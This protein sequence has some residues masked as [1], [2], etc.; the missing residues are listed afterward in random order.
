MTYPSASISRR[1]SSGPRCR[2]Q[3]MHRFSP[4]CFIFFIFRP[5]HLQR[6]IS[7]MSFVLAPSRTSRPRLTDATVRA[8][9]LGLAS[10]CERIAQRRPSCEA[11]TP[12][13]SRRSR[14]HAFRWQGL[15]SQSPTVLRASGCYCCL[16]LISRTR[17]LVLA[18]GAPLG[19][20]HEVTPVIG[21][22]L[23]TRLPASYPPLVPNPSAPDRTEAFPLARASSSP[24]LQT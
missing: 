6:A 13:S 1:R 4:L 8:P 7:G 18:A 21:L 2:S 5:H 20:H 3:A 11:W 17:N 16:N 12:G 23:L 9:S 15:R 10:A 19:P 24:S 22:K 14:I